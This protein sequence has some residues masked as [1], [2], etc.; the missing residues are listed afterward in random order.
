MRRE[1]RIR[2]LAIPFLVLICQAVGYV[3]PCGTSWRASRLRL[4]AVTSMEELATQRKGIRGLDFSAGAVSISNPG[5]QRR[6]FRPLGLRLL[7]SVN[8]EA[9]FLRYGRR[10]LEHLIPKLDS[11]WLA[12]IASISSGELVKREVK[13]QLDALPEPERSVANSLFEE[14][15]KNIYA[16]LLEVEARGWDWE[17][18]LSEELPELLQSVAGP[19]GQQVLEALLKLQAKRLVRGVSESTLSPEAQQQ[20]DSIG[21]LYEKLQQTDFTVGDLTFDEVYAAGLG[22]A[23]P[24]PLMQDVVKLLSTNNITSYAVASIEEEVESA[25]TL[26]SMASRLSD[27]AMMARTVA[28]TALAVEAEAIDSVRLGLDTLQ[29]GIRETLT[30]MEQDLET[31]ATHRMRRKSFKEAYNVKDLISMS[32]SAVVKVVKTA[33]SSFETV[34]EWFNESFDS[35]VEPSK[36]GLPSPSQLLPW[37]ERGNATSKATTF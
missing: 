27:G 3:P 32:S 11:F 26:A 17:P 10:L 33:K 23:P 20:L 7:Y 2:F 24:P 36:R 29:V 8:W 5:V 30:E 37:E 34:T 35:I 14:T 4:Q 16:K 21:L 13:D 9:L 19:Q 22:S 6:F 31:R 28:Y 25:V 15:V 1:R 18:M 12:I